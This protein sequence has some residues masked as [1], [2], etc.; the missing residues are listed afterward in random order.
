MKEKI[1]L[2]TYIIFGNILIAFALSTLVLENNIIAGGITGFGRILNYFI[3]TSVTSVV[4]ITNTI[5]FLL[6]L[7]FIGKKFTLS[8]LVST[9]LFP[10]LL[11]SFQNQEIIHHYCRNTLLSCIL[12]G[13]LIGIGIGIILKANASTG[14]T[15]IIAILVNKKFNVPIFITLNIIDLLILILQI[16]FSSISKIIYGLIVVFITSFMV[17]KTLNINKSMVQT[18]L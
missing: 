15:D 13:C 1:K 9:F 17:N 3:G 16:S 7:F 4:F 5:L 2:L 11:Q 12:A 14:G 10:I 8:T 6:A 18:E